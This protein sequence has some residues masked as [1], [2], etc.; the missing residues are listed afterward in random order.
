M[1]GME[2]CYT[3]GIS[4][5][6]AISRKTSGHFCRQQKLFRDQICHPVVSYKDITDADAVA[7]RRRRNRICD[8]NVVDVIGFVSIFLVRFNWM[9]MPTNY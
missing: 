5:G 4:I 3:F 9:K 6:L 1:D 7:A 8:R 2:E